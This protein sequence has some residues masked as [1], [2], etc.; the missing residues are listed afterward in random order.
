MKQRLASAAVRVIPESVLKKH[1]DSKTMQVELER[2]TLRRDIDRLKANLRLLQVEEGWL[3]KNLKGDQSSDP[4]KGEAWSAAYNK[5]KKVSQRLQD[6]QRQV[7]HLPSG[8][9][10]F[11]DLPSGVSAATTDADGR[12]T[13]S[14][15]RRGRY[16]LIARASREV[17]NG[18]ETFFWLVWVA[19][20]GQPTQHLTLSNDNMLRAGAI[21]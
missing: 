18:T 9:Y 12:F 4:R 14:I 10:F 8:E 16:G 5:C 20:D 1:L 11:A 13:L 15:P 19:L 17:F 6:L 3:W 21:E 2:R 7:Q